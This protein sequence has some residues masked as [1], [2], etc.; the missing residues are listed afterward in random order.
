MDD[1]AA[2][3]GCNDYLTLTGQFQKP[4]YEKDEY[5]IDEQVQCDTCF[6]RKHDND[7][8]INKEA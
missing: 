6:Q 2:T 3:S 1:T 8:S 4:K 7:V 5:T